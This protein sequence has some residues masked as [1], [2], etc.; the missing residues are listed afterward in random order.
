MIYDFLK[1]HVG[2]PIVRH[3]LRPTVVGLERVPAQGAA[4]LAGNHISAGDTFPVPILVRRRIYF[5]GKQALFTAKNPKGRL[6][7]FILRFAGQ[8]PID[9]QGGASSHGSLGRL[10]AILQGGGLV[11]IFPEGTR[12]P[13]GRMY[14]FH[15]GVARLALA[16]GAPVLPMAC[17][18]TKLGRGFLGL[19]T[20]KDARITLGAPLDFRAWQGR[21]DDPAALRWVSDQVAAAVQAMTSQAYVDV[22]ANRVKSGELTPEQAEAFVIDHPGQKTPRPPTNDELAAAGGT[23]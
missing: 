1:W 11:G 15:T 3:V 4:L 6:L 12:S 5:P 18:N 8:V 10:V 23:R 14:R 7:A 19:P 17:C 22:Y 2:A 13:D 16:T 9:P 21:Q 20:M